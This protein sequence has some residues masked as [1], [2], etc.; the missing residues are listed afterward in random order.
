MIFHMQIYRNLQM[1]HVEP[2]IRN[3]NI[4]GTYWAECLNDIPIA[5]THIWT[6]CCRFP[7]WFLKYLDL[8]TKS[9]SLLE[10]CIVYFNND[11]QRKHGQHQS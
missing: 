5:L 6:L 1:E 7:H 4:F 11:R 9:Y 10:N 8:S 3:L 2:I